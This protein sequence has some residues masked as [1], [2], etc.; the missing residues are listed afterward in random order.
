MCLPRVRV[1]R[2]SIAAALALST[3]AALGPAGCGD[4]EPHYR[5]KTAATWAAEVWSPVN[6][7]A[8]R[9]V[10]SIIAFAK[11]HPELAVGAL[12]DQLVRPRP[13][14]PST[15]FSLRLDARGA[16]R[17]ALDPSTPPEI[18]AVD[19]PHLR[20]LVN[21]LGLRLSI[22]RGHAKGDIDVIL[23]GPHT[24]REAER[25]QLL[26]CRR[27]A[28][29]LR[30]ILVPVEGPEA[31][32]EAYRTWFEEDRRR[33]EEADRT[34]TPY[35]PARPDRRVAR[36]DPG[37]GGG[38]GPFLA[39]EEPLELENALDERLIESAEGF[40][41]T[42]GVGRVRIRVR[43]E[44]REGLRRYTTRFVGRYL[45]VL[46]DGL[47]VERLPVG[48]PLTAEIVL[49]AAG[50]A[51]T[52]EEQGTRARED[53]GA[54]RTGRMPWPIEPVPL[55]DTFDADPK[56]ANPVSRTLVAIGLPALPRLE[57]LA[58]SDAPAWSKASAAWAIAQIRRAEEIRRQDAEH[59]K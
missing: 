39:L 42:N 36:V 56:P 46:R 32:R 53:A 40:V 38:L 9:A 22:V 25:L 51:G 29:D 15:P 57:R 31:E 35:R 13:S 7:E 20:N 43:P 11:T 8:T 24:R 37:T 48:F 44:R 16:A 6:E 4:Q 2:R 54:L 33:L 30:A 12:C 34:S 19:L 28:L 1:R 27:G 18:L 59:E 14:A 55:S 45:A 5:Q 41:D 47:V 23:V 26:V 21:N 10:T 49:R 50:G 58:A 17:L 3:G 52:A